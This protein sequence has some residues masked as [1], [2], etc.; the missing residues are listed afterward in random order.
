[1]DIV[2]FGYVKFH[3]PSSL[4]AYSSR[5]LKYPHCYWLFFSPFLYYMWEAGWPN[6]YALGFDPDRTVFSD[7]TLYTLI[8]PLCI[9]V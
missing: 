9:Q 4:T 1:M 5:T 7:K 6:S 3:M 8:L 2:N